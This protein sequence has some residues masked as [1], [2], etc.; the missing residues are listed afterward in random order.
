MKKRYGQTIKVLS[1]TSM[2]LSVLL[3]ADGIYNTFALKNIVG[4]AEICAGLGFLGY[5]AYFR[6]ARKR[7][8]GDYLNSIPS[9]ENRRISANVMESFP[10]PVA[11]LHMDGTFRWY[12]SNF[13]GMFTDKDL[14]G[15]SVE[16][17]IPELK[18]SEILKRASNINAEAQ[19]EGK[20][21]RV[22]GQMI[23]NRGVSNIKE[24]DR[25]A[26]Y[27]YFIDYTKEYEFSQMY[28]QN[29]TDIA[30][31]N[32]DNYDD[33][34]QRIN[35]AE[36]Q[37][38]T[39]GIGRTMNNWAAMSEA[40][41]KKLDRDR[42]LMLFA[43]KYLP[44]YMESKFKILDEVRAIGDEVKIPVS[45][46]IG[47][48]I[49]ESVKESES[50]ARSAMDMALGRGGDQVC[51]KDETQYSFYGGKSKEYEK[52]TRVKTRAVALALKDFIKQSENVVFVGHSNADYDC[53]GAAVGLQRAVRAL[54]KKPFIIYDGNSPA[55]SRMYEEALQVDEYHGM[56]IDVSEAMELLEDNTLLVVLDTH[57][58]SLLP[59]SELISAA[60]KTVLI[61]HHRRSTE[62]INPC[63]LIYHEAYASSTCEM[64]TE[65]IEYMDIGS[66]ITRYEAQCL[67]TGILM[68]TKNFMLKT[69]VRTFEAASYLKRLGL[70]TVDVKKMFNVNKTDYD[71]KVDIVKTAVE[72]VP[73]MAV[74]KTYDKYPNSR[75]IASQAA[76]EMLNLNNI[77]ASFV[78]LPIDDSVS[79]SARSL[80]E[81]NVH[82]IMEAL[83]GGGHMNVAGAQFTSATVDEVEE[84][85]VKAI[86]DYVE[87]SMS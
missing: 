87:E 64:A 33:L 20:K 48:G 63:S 72:V 16:K 85:L 77:R 18:W 34:M 51:I 75:V 11:V 21:Y 38:I 43:H 14:F 2:L 56:F 17:I 6:K 80:G 47:I 71:H 78:I 57:R 59:G 37:K 42:Y 67:Y 58:P 53:F 49:G 23:N 8:V 28:E 19:I 86:K 50:Y 52:S 24:E 83:G 15:A 32:I 1:S 30:V 66:E 55:I 27:L 82:L 39:S 7:K 74:A 54:G 73:N 81:I 4:I 60:Q 41:L 12:N 10:I 35:D 46:S 5:F 65:L 25:M 79:I 61:D 31:I 70:N 36:Q 22:V 69:G 3:V 44:V 76:D 68:D 84:K 29:K 40:I 62:F 9:D 26:V 45:I 13:E